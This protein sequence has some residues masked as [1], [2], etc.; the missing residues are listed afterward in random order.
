MDL[1]RFLL[2]WRTVA[3]RDREVIDALVDPAHAGPS[4]ELRAALNAWPGS[5]YWSDEDGYRHLVLTRPRR[6]ARRENWLLH[7]GLFLATLVTTSWAGATFAGALPASPLFGLPAG[8]ESPGDFLRALGAGMVFSVPL[9]SILLAHELGHYL[10]ARRYDLDASPPYFIPLPLPSLVGTMGAFIRLRTIVTDRRQLVDVAGAGPIAGFLVALPVLWAGLA[11][12]AP[13]AGFD[14]M[15]LWVGGERF[16]LGDSL[17][18]VALRTLVW[19]EVTGLAVHPLAFA[20]WVGMFVTML[21]LLPIAQ[22]DGGHILFAALPRWK[23]RVALAFLGVILVLGWYSAW[24]GWWV[25]GLFVLVLSR[26][27]LGHPPVIDVYRPLPR[28]RRWLAWTAL[29]LFLVTFT[30][31]PFRIVS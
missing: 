5:W 24:P 12:S 25:F 13:V 2:A 26:G 18:T 22:L 19:G 20:G 31:V 1:T 17:I 9:L 21:N 30:P 16:E 8:I 14:G 6:A 28:A 7:V 15:L 27:R 4:A 11:R 23:E 10:T 3:V 29:A